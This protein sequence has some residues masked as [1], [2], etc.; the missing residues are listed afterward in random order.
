MIKTL[1]LLRHGQYLKEPQEK[2]TKLGR[3]Q[4]LLAGERLKEFKINKIYVSTMLRA[5][6]TAQISLGQFVKQRKFESCDLL[7][8]CVPGFPKKL[9]KK[10]GYTKLSE[11]NKD[12]KQADEAF[13]KY[14]TFAKNKKTNLLVCHGNIIRY[15]VCKSL[16]VDTDT[17]MKFDIKQCGITII[18]LNFKNKSLKVI[19]HNETG[20]IPLKLQTFI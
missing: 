2:L 19:T 7:R 10:Y 4:A 13:K 9:R 14:F 5:Q 3:K 1:I 11:L 12:Q 8:E 18:E 17:W 16:G 20:H 15:L 6:E